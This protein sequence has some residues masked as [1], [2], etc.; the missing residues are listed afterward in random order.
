MNIKCDEHK[1]EHEICIS[2]VCTIEIA[3]LLHCIECK[4]TLFKKFRSPFSKFSILCS[5]ILQLEIF[6]RLLLN[7][8]HGTLSAIPL[9]KK[10]RRL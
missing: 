1:R 9:N 7:W 3:Q 4:L 8:Q 5:F 10:F 6:N 2:I